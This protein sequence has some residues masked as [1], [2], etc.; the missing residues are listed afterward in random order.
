MASHIGRRKFLATL[1][2]AAVVWPLAANAQKKP[3]I[4]FLSSRTAADSAHLVAAFRQ[5]VAASGSIAKDA[6]IMFR[7]ADGQFER[8]P[9]LAKDLVARPVAVLVA[10]G[11]DL[12]ALSAKAASTTIPIVFVIG[13]DPVKTGL[14]A[15]INRPGGNITGVNLLTSG[16]ETKRLELLRALLPIGTL[17]AVLG[18]PASPTA[19]TKLPELETAARRVNQPLLILN[20]STEGNLDQ[21]FATLTERKAGGVLVTADPFFNTQRDRLIVLAARHAIPAIFDSREYAVGGGLMSYGANYTDTYRLAGIYAGRILGGAKPSELPIIQ[22]SRFELVIN[23]RTAKTLG[24]ELPPTVL[25]LA[26][27]VIE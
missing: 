18:N 12:T 24:F 27:E 15:S 6:E 1:G 3:T 11:G 10:A 16:V 25:A 23:L 19:G 26:D 2:G 4:G 13:G 9:S 21:A 8:L 7:W 17:I 20:V 22:A 5:G 14:V